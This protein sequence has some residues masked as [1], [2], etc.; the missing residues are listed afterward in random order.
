MKHFLRISGFLLLVVTAPTPLAQQAG[1][2]EAPKTGL[3]PKA[4]QAKPAPAAPQGATSAPR[5]TK[6]GVIDFVRALGET[7]EGQKEFEA[8]QSWA[9]KQNEAAKKEEADFGALRNKYMQDQMKLGPEA[10]A[11][12]ERQLQE[13]EK[14]LTRRQEDLNQELAQK[15]QAIL[16]RMGSKMQQIV[17]EYGQQNNFLAIMVGQ[18]GMFAYVAQAG[19]LTSQMAKLYDAKYPAPGGKK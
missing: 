6:I 8:V 17:Q 3:S 1:K 4:E 16:T 9:T 10:R 19:D 2:A 12:M 14:K 7:A 13:K 5:P 11:D 18:E 15:R